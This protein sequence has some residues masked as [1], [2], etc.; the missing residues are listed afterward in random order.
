[1]PVLLAR[2]DVGHVAGADLL[3]LCASIAAPAG[4]IADVVGDVEGLT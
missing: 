4:D 3:Y 1:M 2:L